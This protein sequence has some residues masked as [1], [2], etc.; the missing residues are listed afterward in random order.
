MFE[1]Y[2]LLGY[3][4]MIDIVVPQILPLI[5]VLYIIAIFDINH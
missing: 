1:S 5:L 4:Q 2:W 3:R